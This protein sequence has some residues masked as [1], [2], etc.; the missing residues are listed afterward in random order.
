MPIPAPKKN[1][2][3]ADF[4]GRCVPIVIEDQDLD[5]ESEKDRNQAVAICGTTWRR[6]REKGSV[7]LWP[8]DLM[9]QARNSPVYKRTNELVSWGVD[10]P[11]AYNIASIE[12]WEDKGKEKGLV[13]IKAMD[14][15]TLTLAGYGVV[16]GGKDLDGDHFTPETDFWFDRITQTP[17]VLY[18]H[19]RDEDVKSVVVGQVGTKAPD[20]VGLWVEAQ[21]ERA[22]EYA[23]AITELVETGKLG[24]SSGAVSHLVE[25]EPDGFLA[26]WPIAEFSLTPTPCEPRTLGVQALRSLAEADPAVKAVLPDGDVADT[27]DAETS[28]ATVAKGPDKAKVGRARALAT[29]IEF[30]LMED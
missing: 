5:A 13:V 29:D 26:S 25:R 4:I 8:P 2:S 16:W 24:W 27:L 22:D 3:Q 21:I 20:D 14:E 23:E 12:C 11:T 15:A 18:D 17:M 30:S 1:E 7:D 19:G 28:G 10:R 6:A 9:E